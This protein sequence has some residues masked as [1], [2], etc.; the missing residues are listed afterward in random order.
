M[1]ISREHAAAL[2]GLGSDASRDQVNR[3]LRV[4]AKLAHPDA[5]A[6]RGHVEDLVQPR[7]VLL[8]AGHAG[9]EPTSGPARS[10]VPRVPLRSVVRRPGRDAWLALALVFAAGVALLLSA[11]FV[12]DPFV[13]DPFVPDLMMALAVGVTAGSAAWL[14]HRGLVL[15]TADTGH[16]ICVLSACWFPLAAALVVIAALHGVTVVA[17]LPIIV[18]PFAMAVALINPGAGLWRPSRSQP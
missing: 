7:A 17:Y 14:L 4:C 13:P 10:C 15:P 6:D 9:N 16:R 1:R 3:A 2:L 11:S 12:P 8:A 18:V 5:G